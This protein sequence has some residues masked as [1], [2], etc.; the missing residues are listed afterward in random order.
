MM[1]GVAGIY[2]YGDIAVLGDLPCATQ[3]ATVA[4]M[5]VPSRPALARDRMRHVGDPVAFVAAET[6]ATVRD[7]A[8][9]GWCTMPAAR[10]RIPSRPCN[11]GHHGSGA[12]AT[13]HS[14]YSG[15]VSRK[16]ALLR[17][18]GLIRKRPQTYRKLLASNGRVVLTALLTVQQASTRELIKCAA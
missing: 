15:A 7:A 6:A 1:H 14:A 12:P 4:L 10:W 18:H 17:A 11:P 3:A 9:Q 16:L 5:T 8:E 13:D 2:T